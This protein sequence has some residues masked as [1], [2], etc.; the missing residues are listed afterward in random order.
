MADGAGLENFLGVRKSLTGR[1]W[2][3]RAADE[4]VAREHQLRHGINDYTHWFVNDPALAGEFYGY[5]GPCPPWNDERV[6]HYVF[7]LYALDMPRLPL[8]GRFTGPQVRMAI[9]GHILDEARIF[10]TDALNPHAVADLPK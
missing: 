9:H 7:T 5:D 8:A 3:R 2:R 4:S 6:H 1:V 10:G